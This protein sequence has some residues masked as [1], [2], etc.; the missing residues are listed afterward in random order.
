MLQPLKHEI[1]SVQLVSRLSMIGVPCN[2]TGKKLC[3]IWSIRR[4]E[5]QFT[6][7]IFF[8]IYFSNYSMQ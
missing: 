4:C 6:F 5:F 2:H 7:S 3:D 8:C 1:S